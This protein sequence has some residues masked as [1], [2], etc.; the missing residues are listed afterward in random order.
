MDYCCYHIIALSQ[1]TFMVIHQNA[2]PAHVTAVV[3][4]CRRR[5][6]IQQFNDLR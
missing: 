2:T 4:L 5:D 1:Y 3:E 6:F